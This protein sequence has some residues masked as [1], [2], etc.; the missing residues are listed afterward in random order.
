MSTA[1]EGEQSTTTQ[2]V[3][4][5]FALSGEELPSARNAGVWTKTAIN[6]FRILLESSRDKAVNGELQNLYDILLV[7]VESEF[8]IAGEG[9]ADLQIELSLTRILRPTATL[10]AI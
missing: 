3:I 4:L 10:A 7:S 8:D 2:R 1:G 9:V 6:N 5:S